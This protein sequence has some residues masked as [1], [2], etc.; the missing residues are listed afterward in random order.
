LIFGNLGFIN[1]NA[2]PVTPAKKHAKAVK[3]KRVATSIH[4]FHRIA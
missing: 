3:N 4:R 2:R 1:G